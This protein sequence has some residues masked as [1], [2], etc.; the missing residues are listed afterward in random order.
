MYL[1]CGKSSLREPRI[2]VDNGVRPTRDRTGTPS[3]MIRQSEAV[4][5]LFVGSLNLNGG[6]RS[7]KEELLDLAKSYGVDVMALSDVRTRDRLEEQL[8]GYK[9]FLSGITCGGRANWGVGIA[10][11]QELVKYITGMNCLNERV[12]WITVK[13]A[14]GIYQFVSVYSPCE[15]SNADDLE[16][17]YDQLQDIVDNN[18]GKLVL[19]GDFNARIGNGRVNSGYDKVVGK[20][21]EDILNSNGRRLLDFCHSHGLAISNSF[22]KHKWIHRYTYMNDS[23]GHKSIIDYVI[24]E[25]DQRQKVRDTRVFRGFTFGSD[26]FFVGSRLSVDKLCENKR[27]KVVVRKFRIGRFKDEAVRALYKAKFA[28]KV[29][30][31]PSEVED[32]EKEWKNFKEFVLSTAEECLGST[33]KGGGNKKTSWWNA[34]IKAAVMEKR[35]VY[36]LWLQDKTE[37]RKEAYRVAKRRV[38]TLIRAAK[39]AA[40]KKFGEELEEAGQ[41]RGKKFWSTIKD[42]RR[43]GEKEE[44]GSILDKDGR[45]VTDKGEVLKTWRDYFQDLFSSVNEVAETAQGLG[46]NVE[47]EE[48]IEI[49]LEEVARKISKLKAGKAAGVDEIRS[50]FLKNSGLAGIQWLS[51]IFNLAMKSSIVPADW[52]YAVIAPIFKKGSRKEC[53]NYRGISLLSVVG[54]VYASV[55]V[56]R[57][58][59]IVEDVLDEI[60]GGFRPLRGCQDQ[61]FCLRQAI[62]KLCEKDKD[63]YLCFIDLEKAFDRVPRQ[64]LFEILSEY[65]I[66][67][68][69]LE[70]IKSIYVGSKAAVRIDGELSEA[71]EV[72]EG[73]RQ[74]CCLSPLLFIIFMDKIIKQANI[75]GDVKVGEVIMKILAYADDLVLMTD[76]VGELQNGI[77]CL[78][79]ACGEF[80]MKISVSKS[81]VMHV[82]KS[83]KE[84]V[85]SLNGEE[86]EQVSVFKYL[87]ALFAEDGKLVKEFEG[88]KKMGNAV[89]SQ[90]RSHVF[91]KKELSSDTKLAIH[92]AIYRP[93]IMYGSESWVDCGYLVHDLEVADM[94]IIRSIARVNRREQWENHIRNEDIRENLG[95]ASVEEA[96]RVSRLRWFGHVQRMGDNRLPK[97]ILSA[98]VPGVRPRGRPRRRFIDSIRSDLEV[99]GLQLDDQTISL[100]DDR[101]AWRGIVHH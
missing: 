15:G 36:L 56:D 70:A 30:S 3:L 17:F 58:R 71:F 65:G 72:N 66:R 92:R 84:V 68:S 35:K 88:R 24:V 33:S 55:L 25:Q 77:N 101:V 91:N 4:G 45:L 39:D 51:R 57:V 99:R 76:N 29:D 67:G 69:L 32:I 93:T 82:G 41:G 16:K 64:K 26:H 74:G 14:G 34:G 10:I 54:K 9:V 83:R 80:G 12:M 63:L 27:K 46:S 47:V 95:V 21:G 48:G 81:K 49:S 1:R 50:E 5:G 85:C 78:N 53:S 7:R 31:L 86:L 60:Q 61:I 90:L 18:K 42:I 43:G 89:A 13:L 40:W 75:Q 98:E 94:R 44:C 100:A 2:R 19:L 6:Y 87:G 59:A 11:K 62:E 8:G 37:E 38:K 96:A 73:V 22:F 28:E 20:F 23:L 79:A 97:K 52:S